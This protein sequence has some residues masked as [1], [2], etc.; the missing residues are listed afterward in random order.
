MNYQDDSSQTGL[1]SPS[2]LSILG[3]NNLA[4]GIQDT[5]QS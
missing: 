1:E 2:K 3:T 4:E 5:I